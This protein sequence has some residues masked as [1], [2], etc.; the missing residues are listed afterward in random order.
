MVQL[1]AAGRLLWVCQMWDVRVY[2]V[3]V[4]EEQSNTQFVSLLFM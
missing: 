4:G 2:S 3:G 1:Q